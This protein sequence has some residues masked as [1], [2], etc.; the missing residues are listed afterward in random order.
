[1]TSLP[2]PV[3]VP[4]A[5]ASHA[6]SLDYVSPEG[7][8]CDPNRTVLDGCLPSPMQ[9]AKGGYNG[10]WISSIDGRTA[11]CVGGGW[12]IS[13]YVG[14]EVDRVCG[15]VI[16]DDR[17]VAGSWRDPNQVCGAYGV[18]SG[19]GIKGNRY[20]PAVVG[21]SGAVSS[22]APDASAAGISVLESGGNAV[23]AA[24]AMVFAVGVVAPESCGIGG[25]GFLL[26]RGA[27]G[28]TAALDFREKAPAG[29]PAQFEALSTQS[30]KMFGTGHLVVGV[31]GT[32]AGMVAARGR[33]GSMPLKRLLEPAIALAERGIRW[34]PKQADSL[35]INRARLERYTAS[36]AQFL[37]QNPPAEGGYRA[38]APYPV[39]EEWKQPDLALTLREI[40]AGG[41]KAFYRGP[42]AQKIVDEMNRSRAEY[43]SDGEKGVMTAD[44]LAR[45]Q[46]VWRTP[47]RGTYRGQ[48]ILAMPPPTAGGIVT[49]STLNLIE[50][51]KWL[52]R[53]STDGVGFD[54]SSAD[55]LHLLAEAKKLA[56]ADRDGYVADPDYVAVPTDQLISKDYAAK[57]RLEIDMTTAKEPRP[58]EISGSTPAMTTASPGSM[59]THHISVVDAAGN[60]VA[61]TCSI[62]H[63]FGSAVVVPGAGFL[64]NSQ[65]TDFDEPGKN[66]NGPEPGKRPR[67]SMSPTIVVADGRPRLVLGGVGGPSIPMGVVLAISNVLDYNMEEAHALDAA[68]VDA[69]GAVGR[70]LALEEHRIPEAER[71]ALVDRGHTIEA[72]GQYDTWFR[73]IVQMVGFKSDGRQFA[74]SDPRY[75][76]GA[77]VREP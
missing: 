35:A 55:H 11:T 70:K 25:G 56:W 74:A 33:Y 49:L 73:P 52:L 20:K 64:L 47:L 26:Y 41:A 75:D 8:L 76:E 44:D 48:E 32:V 30:T 19:N 27:D 59:N 54:H 28:T 67:S 77:K 4:V 62:E 46:A 23:D 24:V 9:C 34:T 13:E 38:P 2:S 45:Y 22:S 36:A 58:G 50:D 3:D 43:T 65:L 71:Q 31:P 53:K 7:N 17:V 60:A 37:V 16:R 29:L 51:E 1:M 15:A 69:E 63:A 12:H 14:G 57:R 10:S 42:I 61:V 72:R 5:L 6:E 18:G 66:K 39:S 40:A 21:R 68:R